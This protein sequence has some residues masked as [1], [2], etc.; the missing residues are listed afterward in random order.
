MRSSRASPM[1]TSALRSPSAPVDLV[2]AA[3]RRGG[4]GGAAARGRSAC[5]RG[6]RPAGRR[7]CAAAPPRARRR[8]RSRPPSARPAGRQQQRAQHPHGGRLAGAVRAEEAVDLARCRPP[9]STPATASLSP[10]RR[11]SPSVITAAV[12]ISSPSSPCHRSGWAVSDPICVQEHG[13]PGVSPDPCSHAHSQRNVT[14]ATT[15]AATA[16][17]ARTIQARAGT[18]APAVSEPRRASERARGGAEPGPRPAGRWAARR[19]G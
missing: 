11:W 9:R 10:K 18:L 2:A 14:A 17:P 8:R 6:R 4:P 12:V 15:G 19:S 3:G 16:H 7:R 1:S 5:R 13:Q